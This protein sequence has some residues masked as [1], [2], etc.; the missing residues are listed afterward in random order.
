[1]RDDNAKPKHFGHGYVLSMATGF[2]LAAFC[3]KMFVFPTTTA[4]PSFINCF[5][6][7]DPL[8][9]EAM[10]WAGLTLAAAILWLSIKKRIT[11]VVCVEATMVWMVAF[12]ALVAASSAPYANI[13]SGVIQN[14]VVIGAVALGGL[15]VVRW[16]VLDQEGRK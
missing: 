11:V 10:F 5:N 1:M 7:I 13:A 14:L 2:A 3:I 4:E 9:G 12:L 6:Y 15:V 8:K 16:N